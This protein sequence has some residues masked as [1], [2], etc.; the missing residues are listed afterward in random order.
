MPVGNIWECDNC[1]F[2]ICTSGLY[3]YYFN[4]SG[5]RRRYGHLGRS[6]EA[7]ESGISGLAPKCGIGKFKESGRFMS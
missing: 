6:E 3:F 2:S 4:K 7:K 5:L 1:K